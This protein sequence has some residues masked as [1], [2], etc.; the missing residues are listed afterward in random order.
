MC[1]VVTLLIMISLLFSCEKESFWNLKKLPELNDIE[2]VNNTLTSFNLKASLKDDGFDEIELTGFCWSLVDITPDIISNPIFSSNTSDQWLMNSSWMTN[3][4]IYVRAFAKNSIGI[5]YSES[6][7][8]FYPG[9]S[10]NI[11][12]V[13]TLAPSNIGFFDLI[14]AGN[15]ISDGG[16]SITEKGFCYSKTNSSPSL[17]N[18]NVFDGDVQVSGN[19][20]TLLSNLS[21]NSNYYVRAYATNFVGTGYG[22]VFQVNTMNYYEIGEQGPAGGLV[23]YSKMDTIEG[24][25]F[26]ELAATESTLIWGNSSGVTN[27]T[28]VEIGAGLENTAAIVST[29][30][31]GIY[32]ASSAFNYSSGGY[33]DWFLPSRNELMKVRENLYLN[34]LG[35]LSPSLEYWSSS[36]DPNFLSNAWVVKMTSTSGNT[37]SNPKSNTLKV[38]PIRRF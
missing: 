19:F 8:L 15:I 37:F 4:K 10:S 30:G 35:N 17:T 32:A 34:Q 23:F 5:S 29:E 22:Q 3:E 26:L 20:E 24:W 31:A 1:R 21:E 25:H 33:S 14:I 7:T 36:E 11:P 13:T 27:Q 16:L 6:L 12:V 28:A 2:I 38:R 9:T 18:Q